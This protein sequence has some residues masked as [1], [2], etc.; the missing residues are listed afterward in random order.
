MQLTVSYASLCALIS[1][2]CFHRVLKPLPAHYHPVD[3][4]LYFSFAAQEYGLFLSDDDPKKGVWLDNSHSLE[5]YLLRN[6]VSIL[7]Y[8][9][10][11]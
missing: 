2:V 8:S 3:E 10:T 6:G 9:E 11:E 7:T 5:Y 4:A 1:L